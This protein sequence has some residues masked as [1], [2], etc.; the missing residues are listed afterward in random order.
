MP[1][2]TKSSLFPAMNR[3]NDRVSIN[4]HPKKGRC[5]IAKK[6]FRKNETIAVD[7]VIV[8]TLKETGKTAL[9]NYTL[10][11]KGRNK[12]ALGL[13]VSV[14]INHGKD[15]NVLFKFD[16]EDKIVGVFAKRTIKK[17]EEL[18]VDYK[19]PLWFDLVED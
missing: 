12:V 1:Q 9:N 17:G 2:V 11:W 6:T 18:S 4:I 3:L 13:G 10:W 8:L 15:P 19:I 16:I 7:P 5:V 14:L